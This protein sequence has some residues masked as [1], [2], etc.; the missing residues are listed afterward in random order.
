MA[1]HN[2]PHR[3]CEER[4]WV[5]TGFMHCRIWDGT[6]PI[7]D[8]KGKLRVPAGNI[9]VLKWNLARYHLGVD[10]PPG[11]ESVTAEI[12]KVTT[13]TSICTILLR[14]LR[15]EKGIH[16]AQV[17]DWIGKTPSAWTKVESGKSPLPFDTFVRVCK[18]FQVWP[19][20]VLATAERY[21]ALLV[22][23]GWAVL[24]SELDSDE[25][26]LLRLAQEYWSSPGCRSAIANRLPRSP[27]PVL[28]GP[29]TSFDNKIMVA[30]TFRFALDQDFRGTQLTPSPGTGTA[31]LL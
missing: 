27:I 3:I 15:T 30:G 2:L 18:S 5:P 21:E 31:S 10:K 12:D 11:A 25:D 28:N 6:Q 14:E 9:G 8:R 19:S 13:I 24:A 26:S 1:T 7:D 17:A 29:Q 20:T 23:C 4:V 16:Q 22:N